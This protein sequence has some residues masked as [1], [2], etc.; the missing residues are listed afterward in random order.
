MPF[1]VEFESD[2]DKVL[3]DLTIEKLGLN[4][5]LPENP[6]ERY[7]KTKKQAE[8]YLEIIASGINYSNDKDK[9]G[10]TINKLFSPI[11]EKKSVQPEW[12]D[13]SAMF[14]APEGASTDHKPESPYIH[15]DFDKPTLY[16]NLGKKSTKL[17]L[18]D[19]EWI[20]FEEGNQ[21]IFPGKIDRSIEKQSYLKESNLFLWKK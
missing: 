20:F 10:L 15:V 4:I 11:D 6:P 13:C 3:K 18:T 9:I 17:E 12:E 7:D 16:G 2:K 5:F 14:M 8:I 1:C 19:D 21:K